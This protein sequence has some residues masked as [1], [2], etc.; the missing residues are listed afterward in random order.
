MRRWLTNGNG[1]GKHPK[2]T[3]SELINRGFAP[4]GDV[5]DVLFIFPPTSI[6]N[7]Y[8]KDDLGDLGGDLPPLGI[9]CLAAFLREKGFGVGIL[10]GCALGL[11]E[12]EVIEV[13]RERNPHVVGFSSTTYALPSA[14]R[15]AQS[16]RTQFPQRA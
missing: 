15:L 11:G 8:G 9:G 10:D 1:N 6:S 13:I 12:G 3:L 4:R 16:V 2:P 14:I 7:R 5:V